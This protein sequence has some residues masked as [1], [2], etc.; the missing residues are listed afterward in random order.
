MSSAS[1]ARFDEIEQIGLDLAQS[2]RG[3]QQ[4]REEADAERNQ[5]VR[6]NS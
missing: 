4:D 1:R 5:D 2:A 3:G 6:N